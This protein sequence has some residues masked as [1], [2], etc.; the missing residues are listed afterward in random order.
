MKTYQI[1]VIS[2]SRR[3]VRC[4]IAHNTNRALEIALGMLPDMPMQ[5]ALICKTIGKLTR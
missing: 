2:G 1:T 4:V 5:F 3:D